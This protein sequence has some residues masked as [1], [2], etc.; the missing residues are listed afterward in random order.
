MAGCTQ[1]L[2]LAGHAMSP[3]RSAI[4]KPLEYAAPWLVLAVLLAYSYARFFLH[5]YGINWRG[6]G[7]ITAVF[8]HEREPT[9]HEGDRLLKVGS[10]TFDRFASDLKQDL[11]EG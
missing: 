6:N 11:F 7:D 1:A 5:P 10:V 3:D 4:K 2:L 9:I 8:V